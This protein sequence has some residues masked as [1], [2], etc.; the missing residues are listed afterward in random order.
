MVSTDLFAPLAEMAANHHEK[1][2]G[3]G[4]PLGLEGK[5]LSLEERILAVADI[6]DA[7]SAERP[8]RAPMPRE[9]VA[10]ILNEMAGPKLDAEVVKALLETL[11]ETL[12]A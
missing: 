10:T 12:A 1:L 11:R 7:L 5:E 4:Y 9:T 2:D 8:Y 3:S 6:H